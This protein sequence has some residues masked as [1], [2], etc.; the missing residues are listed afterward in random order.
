MNSLKIFFSNK[1]AYWLVAVIGIAVFIPIALV[2]SLHRSFNHDEFEAIHSGWKI[3]AG[4]KI[5]VDFLQQHHFLVYDLL[6]GVI[7]I[8]GENVKS[9]I[10]SRLLSFAM[11]L[12]VAWLVYRIAKMTYDKNIA[13]LSVFFL[14]SSVIFLQKIL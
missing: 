3:F 4:E 1:P 10:A 7:A 6:S 5:Y 12:G 8:F 9:I 14:S 13:L 2:S 11:A